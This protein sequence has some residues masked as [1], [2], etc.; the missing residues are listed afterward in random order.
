LS[1]CIM[2]FLCVGYVV[3]NGWTQVH[4]SC[5]SLFLFRFVSLCIYI[6]F[7]HTHAC[8]SICIK[9]RREIGFKATC[10]HF[11]RQRTFYVTSPVTFTVYYCIFVSN[12]LEYFG[13][14]TQ[15]LFLHFDRRVRNSYI[16][17]V[18]S[19]SRHVELVRALEQVFIQQVIKHTC[20][21][22]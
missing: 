6:F 7:T 9:G 2:Y 4:N 1:V 13:I 8:I 20:W 11:S 15:S 16:S 10:R 3:K 19:I 5:V 21:V 18:M 12:S 22:S 17:P 14:R